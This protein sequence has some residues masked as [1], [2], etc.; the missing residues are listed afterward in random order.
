MLLLVKKL[1][2]FLRI[3]HPDHILSMHMESRQITPMYMKQNQVHAQNE[4]KLTGMTGKSKFKASPKTPLQV[5]FIH[6]PGTLP[7]IQDR[8]LNRSHALL[9]RTTP[10]LMS[11]RYSDSIRR[12]HSKTSKLS[13]QLSSLPFRTSTVD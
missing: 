7:K 5:K 4:D 10:L 11:Q 9:Q 8:P 6:T 12:L 2:L 13:N 1:K 3:W